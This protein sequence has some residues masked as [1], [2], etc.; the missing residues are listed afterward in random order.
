MMLSLALYMSMYK[1]HTPSVSTTS[2][3]QYF[4][5]RGSTSQ[6][7]IVSCFHKKQSNFSSTSV[8]YSTLEPYDTVLVGNELSGS[9]VGARIDADQ[10]AADV[11]SLKHIIDSNYQGSS[12]PLVLAPGGFF[13]GAWFTKLVDK[14]KPNQLDVITHHIYNLGPGM[15]TLTDHRFGK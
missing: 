15:P 10:Y 3:R 2:Q 13:D 6:C 9:G 7:S 1:P 8:S 11:I 4:E 14:T 12:K 5:N